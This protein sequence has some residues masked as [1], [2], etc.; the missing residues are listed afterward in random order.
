VKTSTKTKIQQILNAFETGSARGN[1]G[2]ISV[3]N[4]APG[5]KKQYTIGRSQTTESGGLKK[6]LQKYIDNKGKYATEMRPFVARIQP[7]TGNGPYTK[8]I[9]PDKN[10]EALIKKAASDPIMIKTQDEF[11]DE[12]YWGPAFK[13][14][15]DNGFTLPLSMLTIYDTAIHSGP[16][17]NSPRSMMSILRKR[18]PEKTP[19]NGGNE[20]KWV[21]QYVN[22]RHSWLANH[23]SRPILRKT[24]YR[25]QTIKNL[26]NSNNWQLNGYIRT[27]NGVWI[28]ENNSTPQNTTPVVSTPAPKEVVVK[29]PKL[30]FWQ[31]I[32]SWFLG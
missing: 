22:A 19:A 15:T 24:V 10:F 9:W 21:E 17:L 12:M 1:Y 29:Q 26:I 2:A 7:H 13:F 8:S 18:F 5:N 28:R 11:F 3:F 23:S 30:T 6:M 14:F 31:K 25:T 16:H 27:G 20:K 4:D 32:K